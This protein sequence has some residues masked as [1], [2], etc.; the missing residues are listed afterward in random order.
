MFTQR[1][2]SLD[3]RDVL[4]YVSAAASTVEYVNDIKYLFLSRIS[5][6]LSNCMLHTDSPTKCKILHVLFFDKKTGI[7]HKA[8]IFPL[9]KNYFL[10]MKLYFFFFP[11]EVSV[12]FHVATIQMACYWVKKFC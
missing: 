3:R 6:M 10:H 1:Y 2:H 5:F 9:S 7:S 12:V 11:G 4:K 8:T